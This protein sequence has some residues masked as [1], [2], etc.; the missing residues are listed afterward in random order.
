M[1]DPQKWDLVWV[2]DDVS[3]ERERERE[4]GR[5]GSLDL[6][7]VRFAFV[8]ITRRGKRGTDGLG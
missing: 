7:R 1:E 2:R 8:V 6:S 3:K 5:T 4:R